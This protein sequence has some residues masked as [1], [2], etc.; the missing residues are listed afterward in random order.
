MTQKHTP[1]PWVIGY[2]NDTGPDDDYFIEWVTAGPAQLHE[3]NADADAR[4]IASAPDLLEAL[5]MAQLWL[6]FDGRFN[7]QKINAA[8]AKAKGEPQ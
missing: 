5:E 3:K 1:G 7:M 6:E 2:D 4:L 8:I